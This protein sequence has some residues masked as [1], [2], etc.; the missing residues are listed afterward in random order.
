MYENRYTFRMVNQATVEKMKQL[1]AENKKVIDHAIE[2]PA[3]EYE[4][5]SMTL[6]RDIATG[7]IQP[8][9]S[10]ITQ[11]PVVSVSV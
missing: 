1:Y 7:T 5:K 3:D 9:M 4:R 11:Q 2:F 8:E 6:I 10:F